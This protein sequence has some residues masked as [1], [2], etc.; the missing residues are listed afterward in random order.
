L[1]LR[2]ALQ[3]WFFL[4]TAS[5][6]HYIIIASGAVHMY[7]ALNGALNANSIYGWDICIGEEQ[8]HLLFRIIFLLIIKEISS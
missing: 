2:G 3:A 5:V 7:P 8:G 4:E 1:K 6:L